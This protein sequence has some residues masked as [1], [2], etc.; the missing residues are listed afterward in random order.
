MAVYAPPL[1]IQS[2]PW[3][4]FSKIP[5]KLKTRNVN[6]YCDS[7][8]LFIATTHHMRTTHTFEALIREYAKSWWTTWSIYGI[9]WKHPDKENFALVEESSKINAIHS[10]GLTRKYWSQ[11]QH[12]FIVV[13][14]DCLLSWGNFREIEIVILGNLS[15]RV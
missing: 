14:H 12:L 11:T 2:L 7:K 1:C 6:T 9:K 4:W 3:L 8:D 10:A 15:E 5:G 13:Y